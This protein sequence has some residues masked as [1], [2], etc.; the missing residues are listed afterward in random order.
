M[1]ADIAEPAVPDMAERADHAVEEWLAA[2]KPAL[3]M[4]L[5]LRGEMLAR[6]EPDLDFER[7]VVAEQR[8]RVE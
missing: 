4:C 7:P 6:T 8:P 5:G 1:K 3:G 2:D